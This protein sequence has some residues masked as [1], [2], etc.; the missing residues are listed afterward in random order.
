MYLVVR[1]QYG[2]VARPHQLPDP[3]HARP[4]Q[5]A[6]EL[7]VLQELAIVYVRLQQIIRVQCSNN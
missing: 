7:P 2:L 4:V 6:P 5:V 3:V 1:S